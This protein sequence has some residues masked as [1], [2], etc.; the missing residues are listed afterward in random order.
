MQ[1]YNNLKQQFQET[2][3]GFSQSPEQ[4]LYLTQNKPPLV[5]S[6][7]MWN[8]NVY[9][10]PKWEKRDIKHVESNNHTPFPIRNYINYVQQHSEGFS[11][12]LNL[13]FL[14]HLI[15]LFTVNQWWVDQTK[16]FKR[17]IPINI[18]QMPSKNQVE[19]SNLQL[20]IQKSFDDLNFYNKILSSTKSPPI[21][22]PQNQL[23]EYKSSVTYQVLDLNASEK[24]KDYS[25]FQLQDL[26]IKRIMQLL[27]ERGLPSLGYYDYLTFQQ[28]VE[29]Q[30]KGI[31]DAE[32]FMKVLEIKRLFNQ[33]DLISQQNEHLTNQWESEYQK[34]QVENP[35]KFRR[36]NQE[37]TLLSDEILDLASYVGFDVNLKRARKNY[38]LHKTEHQFNE[39]II[40]G[41]QISA[42]A[43]KIILDTQSKLSKFEYEVVQTADQIKKDPLDQNIKIAQNQQEQEIHQVQDKKIEYFNTE[44][45][46]NLHNVQIERFHTQRQK[47]QEDLI[48]NNIQKQTKSFHFPQQLS[49]DRTQFSNQKQPNKQKISFN[50]PPQKKS[51]LISENN[52]KTQNPL[53]SQQQQYR[54]F[55]YSS[56]ERKQ[57]ITRLDER[58]EHS[59]KQNRNLQ[60]QKSQ[61]SL[62]SY[63]EFIRPI[64]NISSTNLPA[65]QL[66]NFHTTSEI[67]QNLSSHQNKQS[68][69]ITSYNS[70]SLHQNR[71]N[72][73]KTNDLRVMKEYIKKNKKYKTE[74]QEKLLYSDKNIGE[75]DFDETKPNPNFNQVNESQDLSD[76]LDLLPSIT[77]RDVRPYDQQNQENEIYNSIPESTSNNTTARTLRNTSNYNP[78]LPKKQKQEHQDQP[79]HD[80]PEQLQTINEISRKISPVLIRQS[81]MKND[82]R[83][84]ENQSHLKPSK[85]FQGEKVSNQIHSQ[86]PEIVIHQEPKHDETNTNN[87]SQNSIDLPSQKTRNTNGIN[88]KSKNFLKSSIH[89][90]DKQQIQK[91]H[92]KAETT[93]KS[94]ENQQ[95]YKRTKN[96]YVKQEVLDDPMEDESEEESEEES[97]DDEVEV[98]QVNNV[99]GKQMKRKKKAKV[100]SLSTSQLERIEDHKRYLKFLKEELKEML[101]KK[102]NLKEIKEHINIILSEIGSLSLDQELDYYIQLYKSRAQEL[103]Q[104]NQE[105]HEIRFQNQQPVVELRLKREIKGLKFAKDCDRI[106]K[107]KPSDLEDMDETQNLIKI[108]EELN[109]QDLNTNQYATQ[110]RYES[111]PSPLQT[112]IIQVSLDVTR[113]QTPNQKRMYRTN[114]RFESDLTTYNQKKKAAIRNAKKQ[115]QS[116]HIQH[117]A[118]KKE[119]LNDNF[120]YLHK[121]KPELLKSVLEA[122]ISLEQLI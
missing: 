48:S 80:K 7:S 34:N 70:I 26:F 74:L 97:E 46:K 19:Q 13:D 10:V 50:T 108:E 58:N 41:D 122:R 77:Q 22:L 81:S 87:Y 21:P 66:H 83:N 92:Q 114:P 117:I 23:H 1:I 72:V 84:N 20:L 110:Y 37:N 28:I 113:S 109:D 59:V 45:S 12:S 62:R 111:R 31:C 65:P 106:T 63:E 43:Q 107:L 75:D 69:I 17:T 32:T 25:L 11:N 36:W 67:N 16:K 119:P 18:L 40:I 98:E 100:Q 14:K 120:P 30:K 8:K 73:H 5:E 39:L 38:E 57:Y 4:G 121:Y 53:K 27:S 51:I 91:D 61:Q 104:V 105:S 95:E 99:T 82:P 68:Q 52:L 33:I 78:V 47:P 3:R 2:K 24:Y 15:R 56:N 35:K 60:S 112:N 102:V 54:K 116:K 71:K 86:I 79:K 44:S 9:L 93:N 115:K 42:T 96:K 64:E 101:D 76:D 6:R 94:Q 29:D 103:N 89:F 49:T 55:H 85:E 118:F 88:E 90:S